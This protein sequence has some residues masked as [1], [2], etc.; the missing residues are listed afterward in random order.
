MEITMLSH[1]D[2]TQLLILV[3]DASVYGLGAVL[4]MRDEE[5]KKRL[6]CH[7]SKIFSPSQKNWNQLDKRAAADIFG[8]SKF[9]D[10]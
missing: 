2:G 3:K 7:A 9:T 6:L 5:E 1:Y 4:L 8:V 10:Y